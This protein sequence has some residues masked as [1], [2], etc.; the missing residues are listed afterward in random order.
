ML[1]IILPQFMS[2]AHYTTANA[3]DGMERLG[4][5]CLTAFV[6]AVC[7]IRPRTESR[8]GID[9]YKYIVPLLHG[10][11]LNSRQAQSSLVRLVEGGER[12]KFPDHLQSVL[13]QNWSVTE[14]NRTITCMVLKATEN[15]RCKPTP[16]HDE[17][18]VA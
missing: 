14:S 9:V 6:T 17:F 1:K 13:P 4:V 2:N 15:D 5:I 8:E 7:H 11:T 10:Y 12:W 16:F 18:R 3:P